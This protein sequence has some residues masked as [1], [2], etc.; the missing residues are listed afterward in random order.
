MGAWVQLEGGLQGV[1]GEKFWCQTS[2]L[3][4]LLCWVTLG[5]SL[6]WASCP[7]QVR[8]TPLLFRDCR[9]EPS[10]EYPAQNCF[11]TS[12]SFHSA[13][14]TK[15]IFPYIA[16]TF[17]ELITLHI[18]L[19]CPAQ[20]N[21]TAWPHGWLTPRSCQLPRSTALSWASWCWQLLARHLHG[22]GTS[23]RCPRRPSCLAG[24]REY[25]ILLLLQ[26]TSEE[27]AARRGEGTCPGLHSKVTAG[28]RALT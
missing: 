17:R 19:L 22:G 12:C 26:L 15:A 14:E 18:P 4:Y 3:C 1:D 10:R 11:L 8:I 25:R 6:L 21:A 7:L 13:G 20:L 28:T 27:T 16:L 2:H 24:T 5:K 9:A 23:P